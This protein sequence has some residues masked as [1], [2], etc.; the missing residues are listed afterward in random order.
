LN[1]RYCELSEEIF[2]MGGITEVELV[3]WLIIP[4]MVGKVD[5]YVFV[6]DV[7]F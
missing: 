1:E 3:I 5:L 7:S 2:E 4:E 6:T